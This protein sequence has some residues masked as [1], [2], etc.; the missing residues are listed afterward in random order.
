M[1]S[2]QTTADHALRIQKLH[3]RGMVEFGCSCGWQWGGFTTEE[4]ARSVHLD[5]VEYALHGHLR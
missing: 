3:P 2:D 5:H 1:T 4:V